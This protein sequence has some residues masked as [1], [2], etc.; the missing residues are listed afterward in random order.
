MSLSH[1]LDWRSSSHQH[2]RLASCNHRKPSPRV[3]YSTVQ[4]LLTSPAIHGPV[5]PIHPAPVAGGATST[6]MPTISSPA[7]N[8]HSGRR[9]VPHGTLPLWVVLPPYTLWPPNVQTGMQL[10]PWYF[11]KQQGKSLN[12]STNK[13]QAFTHY[14][15][16][17]QHF[18]TGCIQRHASLHSR[19]ASID[20]FRFN[21]GGWC[22]SC[23]T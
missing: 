2:G 9:S 3:Q 13:L 15:V 12:G 10:P 18:A 23:K 4:S 14:G 1:T 7:Q 20:R 19:S 6:R 16:V 8:N 22:K 11:C 21:R 17:E 5:Q